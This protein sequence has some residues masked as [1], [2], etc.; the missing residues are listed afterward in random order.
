[1]RYNN[2][3]KLLEVEQMDYKCFD[4]PIKPRW[5]GVDI[6]KNILCACPV[7]AQ[8]IVDKTEVCTNCG[9]KF[10]YEKGEV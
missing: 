1:M 8:V 7:C 10:T 6:R 4:K 2:G 5:L 3:T 9:Q